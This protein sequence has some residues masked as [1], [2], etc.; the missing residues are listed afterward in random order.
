MSSTESSAFAKSTWP[1]LGRG[2]PLLLL[3]GIGLFQATIAL[4]VCLLPTGGTLRN[5]VGSVAGN[6]FLTF[7]AAAKLVHAG[8]ASAIFDQAHIF[9][10]QDN[11][12]GL[13]Q[14]FPWAYPPIF[15]LIVAGLAFLPYGVALAL[16]LGLTSLSFG[17]GMQRLSGLA[18]P[19]V[20]LLPPVV[21]NAMDGQ[22]GALTAA[23]FTAGLAALTARRPLL[24]GLLFGCLAYKPQVFLLAPIGLIASREWKALLAALAA[25]LALALLS[26][27]AFGL[28]IWWKFAAHLQDHLSYVLA[29]RL[30]SDRFPT[31]FIFV[32]KLTQSAALAKAAQIASSLF[33]FGFI[34]WVW[35]RSR[36]VLPRA[37]AFCLALPL[38]TPFML[39]YDLAIWG[40]PAALILMQLWKTP[41]HWSD[42]AALAVLALL[43]PAIYY[44]ALAG[45]NFWIVP[46]AALVPYAVRR[47]TDEAACAPV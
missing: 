19:L 28:D 4:P 17:Y 15:L 31:T 2:L 5:A 40:L 20:L 29:G 41:G 6:D 8:T 12:S 22:N 46:I 30:P 43:P 21:Q 9:A 10:V 7:Y 13:T 11:I 33:A 45:M 16:W 3:I 39:E 32:F 26:V 44:G 47:T 24:A 42:W 35:R 25:S 36:A 27:A 14:H 18:L 37:L 23:L 34:Y 38:S 1:P